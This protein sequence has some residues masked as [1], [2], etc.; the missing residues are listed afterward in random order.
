MNK[1]QS[2]AILVVLMLAACTGV[3]P[4]WKA[5]LA[6]QSYY[7]C[8][9]KGDAVRFM[10]GK[11]GIGGQPASYCEQL[12][13]A[14]EEYHA[15]IQQKHGGLA[16]IRISDNTTLLADTMHAASVVNAFLIL[17]YRDSTQEEIVVPMVQDGEGEWRMK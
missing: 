10:E 17:C 15:V 11:A 4:E 14:V 13:K 16:G 3:T 12:L 6:A 1:L 2:L 7:E 9:A 8:L 5:A